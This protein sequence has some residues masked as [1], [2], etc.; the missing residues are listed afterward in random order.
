MIQSKTCDNTHFCYES[1]NKSCAKHDYS[2]TVRVPLYFLLGTVI[3]FT[4]FGNLF[5]IIT[6]AHFKQLHTPTNFLILSLAATDFL[7]GAVIMPP[8]MVRSLETCWYLGNI[9]CK[10]H[11]STDT[12][13]S[14]I[15]ILNL[16]LI[17]V[18]RYYAVC[19]PLH[20][21]TKMTTCVT[22]TMILICW[23]LSAFIGFGMLFSGFNSW[24]TDT[25]IEM[26][27][28]DG[29]CILL[30]SRM[31]SVFFSVIAFIIPA[32]FIIV[33]YLKILLVARRQASSIQSRVGA[34]VN[35]Q[36]SKGNFNKTEP[37]ATRTLGTV[38][39]IYFAC[40]APWFLCSLN[41]PVI[42]FSLPIFSEVLIWLG[43]LNSGINPILYA[44][45]FGW[46]RKPFKTVFLKI[47]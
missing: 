4:V 13:L 16:S 38:V 45:S 40:W 34:N 33:L 26:Y 36:K 9:F 42:F 37:K 18:D 3:I 32:F 35:L 39:G 6:I 5:V 27:N 11:T 28:C 21:H 46:F 47:F 19:H 17:S 31:S 29:S 10:I 8:S 43:Y 7:L 14:T 44:F 22:T 20:Y 15:S 1:S 25:H 2:A 12:M 23:S 24:G 30:Q 41:D